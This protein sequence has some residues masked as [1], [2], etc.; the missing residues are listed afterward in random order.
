MSFPCRKGHIHT[1][2]AA[3]DACHLRQA[4][5][6]MKRLLGSGP[7]RAA[8]ALRHFPAR[9]ERR[10]PFEVAVFYEQAPDPD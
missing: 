4:E 9:V 5:R 6:R 2:E 3:R 7:I 10:G 8:E 1:S